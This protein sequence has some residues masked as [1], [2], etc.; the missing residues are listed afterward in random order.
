MAI[1]T[2]GSGKQYSKLS[3]A[4][5]ASRDGDT[6][7]VDAGT[8]TN[9]YA[10]INT[11]IS[12]VGVGGMV[13]LVNNQNI[14]NGKGIFITN[15]DV[16]LDHIEFSGARN[17]GGNGA[18]IRHQGGN[19]VIKNSYFH[20]NEN[21]ILSA[22]SNGTISIYKSEFARNGSGDG[23]THG[24]YAGNI[25]KLYITDSYFHD[26]NAGH[27][28]KSRAQE[29]IVENSR[30]DDGNSPTAYNID[31]PNGGKGLIRN[32]VIV[33]GPNS[34]NSAIIHFGGEGGAPYAG[35]ALRVENNTIENLR[36]SGIGVL[37]QTNSSVAIV[38]NKFYKVTTIASGPNSQSGST[39][40]SSFVAVDKT[41]PWTGTSTTPPTTN[42]A[43]VA[44]D[45]SATT[46]VGTA[47]IIK[48]MA[49]DSDPDGDAI[50][51]KGIATMPGHGTAAVNADGAITYQPVAGYV[52][53]DT[54]I[55]TLTDSKGATDTAKV[56]V[57]VTSGTTT[58]DGPIPLPAPTI[59]GNDSNNIL[60]GTASSDAIDGRGGSDTMYGRDGHDTYYLD[61][62]S[63]MVVEN[64]GQGYDTV[65]A[66][67]TYYLPANV[68]RLVLA[69]GAGAIEGRGNGGDN[70]LY[71][72]ESANYLRGYQGN[73][74]I[75]GGKGNDVLY[76]N[77]GRD[78]FVYSHVGDGHDS[79]RDYVQGTDLI[80]LRQ[81]AVNGATVS[82]KANTVGGSDIWLDPD[83]SGSMAA[84]NIMS[85]S[86]TTPDK[87][88]IGTDILIA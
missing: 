57:N 58:T 17:S 26:T 84:Q 38:N 48:V 4:I 43:P 56:T 66:K 20:D 10:T 3:S 69:Q 22:P 28:V 19:L 14:P 2:V 65:V 50:A 25:A 88:K 49:N 70:A 39:T 15:V 85:V 35:S 67:A 34:G 6:I 23:Y 53:G 80:D 24:V 75:D 55:Y 32:N 61:R 73:D 5:A 11:K 30:L 8:Y 46:A 86:Y 37:N 76:G 83:G 12:I 52:G 71:G 7:Q 47:A 27:H 62:A 31:I 81:V 82:V 45:D 79:V 60:Y 87:L 13:K 18:G 33:Q 40:L 59:V 44:N 9:D 64:A 1:I 16:T 72:N 41:S 21:G 36:S 51:V 42:A 63:D 74:R 54:F 77:D 68:E 78:V 29:T